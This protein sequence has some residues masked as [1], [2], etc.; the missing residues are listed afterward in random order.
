MALAGRATTGAEPAPLAAATTTGAAPK[1]TLDAPMA[2][3]EAAAI[4]GGGNATAGAGAG[5]GAAAITGAGTGAGTT[6]EAGRAAETGAAVPGP[7]VAVALG[8]GGCEALW[9]RLRSVRF[10]FSS[11]T[12]AASAWRWRSVER[13][14]S[15]LPAAD[16]GVAP[17]LLSLSVSGLAL[18]GCFLSSTDAVTRPVLC[19]LFGSPQPGAVDRRRSP[20]FAR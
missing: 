20:R 10:L 4:T 5:D 18:A 6:V 2:G 9:M 17:P 13:R 7:V 19:R 16:G 15:A 8:A 12:R 14:S 3:V 1:A 11:A